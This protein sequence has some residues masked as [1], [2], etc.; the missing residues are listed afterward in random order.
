MCDKGNTNPFA[1]LFGAINEGNVQGDPIIEDTANVNQFVERPVEKEPTP[2]PTEQPIN[3]QEEFTEADRIIADIFGLTMKSSGF[4]PHQLVFLNT[5]SVEHAVFERLMLPDPKAHLLPKV[6]TQG[7]ILDSH[8]VQMHNITYL[9][10][11]YSRLFK[12]NS[13]TI[14]R[15]IIEDLE[16]QQIIL[17]NVGTALQEPDLF[18]GQEV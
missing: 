13:N 18:P 9:Y 10:E 12:Y 11:C 16:L 14:A 4:A 17:R 6:F 15:K 5:D 1:S 8:V 7:L 3:N 2:C